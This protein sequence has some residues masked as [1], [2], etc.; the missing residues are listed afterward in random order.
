MVCRSNDVPDY[1]EVGQMRT[2]CIFNFW[3]L[4]DFYLFEILDILTFFVPQSFASH[5]MPTSFYVTKAQPIER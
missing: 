3:E 5:A 2:V 1:W 4:R